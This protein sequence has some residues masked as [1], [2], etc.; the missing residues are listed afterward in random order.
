MVQIINHGIVTNVRMRTLYNPGL[1]A[2]LL[3]HWP[4]GLYYIAFVREHHLAT[5]ADYVV[6][7]VGAFASLVVLWLG[8]IRLLRD[9]NSKYP[10]AEVEMF[11]FRG[12]R[13]KEMLKS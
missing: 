11:K 1:A 5:P 12:E 9:R 13:L 8:P 3:L 10:F 2:V 6:G 7:L 4:L